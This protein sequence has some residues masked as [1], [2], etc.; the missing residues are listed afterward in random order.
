MQP[1]PGFAW[2]LPLMAL[3]GP[4]AGTLAL[5]ACDRPRPAP[6]LV[7][8]EKPIPIQPIPTGQQG[9]CW[10][11]HAWLLSHGI[12]DAEARFWDVADIPAH[13]VRGLNVRNVEWAYVDLHG[14]SLLACDFRGCDLRGA[15]LRDVRL[16][17]C[18]FA[19]ADLTDTDLTGA[20]FDRGTRW[21]AGFDAQ[22]HGARLAE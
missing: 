11:A 13:T 17:D 2:L 18:G 6:M 10:V 16:W 9:G 15:N 3:T 4:A 1:R 20:T 22:A 12:V 14:A 7:I 8:T 19:G 5:L 21:P